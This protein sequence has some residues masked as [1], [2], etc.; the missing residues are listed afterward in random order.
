MKRTLI[1]EIQDKKDLLIHLLKDIAPAPDGYEW[2]ESW[3]GNICYKS[4]DGGGED[5]R[6]YTNGDT[7][8]EEYHILCSILDTLMIVYSNTD[9]HE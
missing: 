8:R 1:Q 7:L 9:N 2:A 3:N 4:T 5:I 6:I